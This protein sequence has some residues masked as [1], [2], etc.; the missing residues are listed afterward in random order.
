M[1]STLM[2]KDLALDKQLD[3]KEMSAVR[4]GFTAVNYF[5]QKQHVDQNN[6]GPGFSI[7]NS[8]TNS[9]IGVFAPVSVDAHTD[10]KSMSNVLGNLKGFQI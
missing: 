1:K 9:Q 6:G 3:G 8:N 2:I 10:L 4:G 7:G 5:D